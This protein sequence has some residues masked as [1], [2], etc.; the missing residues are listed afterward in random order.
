LQPSCF[1]FFFTLL[2]SSPDVEDKAS[3]ITD[4]LLTH[5]RSGNMGLVGGA[6]NSPALL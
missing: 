6:G 5:A 2:V 1:F 3:P 4:E